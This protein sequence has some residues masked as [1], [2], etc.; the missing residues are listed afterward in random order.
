MSGD[1]RS[2]QKNGPVADLLTEIGELL[3]IK[4][5]QR[6]KINAYHNAAR[7]IESLTEPIETVH[8]ERRLRTI[9]GVG[10]ALEQKISEF[11]ATGS[12]AYLERLRAEI[13]PSLLSLTS[14]PGLGPKKA[15]QIYQQLGI[16]S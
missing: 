16:A 15:H 7:R 5:E 1:A 4:G 13:P 3:E 8:A 9:P 14:V 12:L 10:D 6:F 2:R 11:L